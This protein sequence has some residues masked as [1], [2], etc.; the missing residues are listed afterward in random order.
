MK[1]LCVLFLLFLTYSVIG[2][3]IEI[4]N[5]LVRVKKFTNRGYLIGP[6]CPIYGCGSVLAIL[7]LG[8]YS[9]DILALF[10]LS[11]VLFSVV[12]YSTSYFMEKLF[13]ARW[14]DYHNRKYNING[15]ICLETMVPFGLLGV[16]LVSVINPILA[17]F[18]ASWPDTLIYIIS[19]IFALMLIA[20]NI[21]SFTII[22]KY[23]ATVKKSPTADSTEEFAALVQ[24]KFLASSTILKRRL[25]NAFPQAQ[26]HPAK[27]KTKSKKAK[28]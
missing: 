27:P 19:G 14:W 24:E 8:K 2:W 7:I 9:H 16:L 22:H 5:E 4:V 26:P 25:I 3:C 13:R 18:Y 1:Q 15:R 17:I 20:D 10:I 21:V 23:G 6:L 28:K 12:E 11:V